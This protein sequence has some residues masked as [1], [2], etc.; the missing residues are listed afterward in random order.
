MLS[1]SLRALLRCMEQLLW[2][3][4][5]AVATVLHPS[6]L[7]SCSYPLSVGHREPFLA[8]TLS[9][10]SHTPADCAPR[11][12]A[13]RCGLLPFLAISRRPEGPGL[14]IGISRRPC[15]LNEGFR[16]YHGLYGRY[17]QAECG[18][19]RVLITMCACRIYRSYSSHV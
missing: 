7:S 15:V 2:T 14:P 16:I 6:P 19:E 10:I 5:R 17:F 8:F 3:A 13:P 18:L 4:Q 1:A 11:E 9:W 12:L